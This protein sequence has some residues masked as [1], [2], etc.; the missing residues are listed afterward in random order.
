VLLVL[1]FTT[2]TFVRLR[3]NPA[4][5]KQM[6]RLSYLFFGL[7][8]V[9]LV[10]MLVPAMRNDA[11]ASALSLAV[12]A[13]VLVVYVFARLVRPRL[14]RRDKRVSKNTKPPPPLCSL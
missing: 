14:K 5:W 10:L 4:T 8:H 12:Y 11:A 2:F 1:G 7:I 13:V 3:M 9:H 6:Q